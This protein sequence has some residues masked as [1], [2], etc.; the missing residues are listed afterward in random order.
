MPITCDSLMSD[1][2][3]LHDVTRAI[4]AVDDF[5]VMGRTQLAQI[6][7]V[8]AELARLG[9]PATPFQ[10]GRILS[11]LIRDE[12]AGRFDT[13]RD[14]PSGRDVAEWTILYLR[15]HEGSSIETIARRLN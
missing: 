8:D 7:L 9:L 6:S 3:D 2:S 14:H 13:Y 10:R 4:N 5:G 12:V 15:V 1:A 11:R